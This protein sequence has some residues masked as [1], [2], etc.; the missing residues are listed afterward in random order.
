MG[1]NQKREKKIAEVKIKGKKKA[2][3]RQSTKKII[4]IIRRANNIRVKQT[5]A[6]EKEIRI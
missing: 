6:Q 5:T 4:K 2:E 3:E 1:F